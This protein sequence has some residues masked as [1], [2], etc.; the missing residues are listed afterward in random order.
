MVALRIPY[1]NPARS[2]HVKISLL[3]NF[4]SVRHAITFAARFFSE[5]P[6]IF[7][8]AIGAEIVRTNISLFAVIHV[9]FLSIREKKP[10]H[11]AAIILS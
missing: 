11:S 9:K 4:D 7:Q 10:S 8:A 3:V 2:R 6:S 5:N 1:P